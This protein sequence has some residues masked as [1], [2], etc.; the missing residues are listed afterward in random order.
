MG[1]VMQKSRA[2]GE[3]IDEDG[4]AVDQQHDGR[5]A[6]YRERGPSDRMRMPHE[7][8][9]SAAAATAGGKA[10]AQG[11]VIGQAHED[12]ASGQQDTDLRGEAA[13]ELARTAYPIPRAGAARSHLRGRRAAAACPAR[14]GRAGRRMRRPPGADG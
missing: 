11:E 5:D 1:D 9:E 7:R 13:Q 10:P 6:L 8:D 12:L 2:P 14:L 4:L 3:Q